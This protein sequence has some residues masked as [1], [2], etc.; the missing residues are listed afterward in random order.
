MKVVCLATQIIDTVQ[1]NESCLQLCTQQFRPY[2][3]GCHFVLKMDHG[4]LT[5]LCSFK[6][7]EGQFARHLQRF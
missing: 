1:F 3:L 7:L 4:S 5:C 2:L 6:E